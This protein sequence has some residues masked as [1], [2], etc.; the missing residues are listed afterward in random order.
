[1]TLVRKP[2]RA[3]SGFYGKT[4]LYWEVEGLEIEVHRVSLCDKLI[5]TLFT[6]GFDLWLHL[7]F[8][9]KKI[10]CVIPAKVSDVECNL[11]LSYHSINPSHREQF[12][13]RAIEMTD[14]A[15]G[16][17][18][19]LPKLLKL[20]VE[21]ADEVRL[22]AVQS[23][24]CVFEPRI[25]AEFIQAEKVR[26]GEL[27][28]LLKEVTEVRLSRLSIWP[29]HLVKLEQQSEGEFV[30]V[31]SISEVK[32]TCTVADFIDYVLDMEVRPGNHNS[33]YL[34]QVNFG[35]PEQALG[36]LYVRNQ[37]AL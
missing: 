8:Q 10:E 5:D 31:S 2:E 33:L 21:Q 13:A 23:G 26:P 17:Q 30:V 18:L 19:P 36:L 14:L 12:L 22:I 27:V 29:N 1:M 7:I 37:R 28:K 32:K 20:K 24:I 6:G 25:N 11:H 4:Y 35:V 16:E 3:L 15:T 9:G 34:H